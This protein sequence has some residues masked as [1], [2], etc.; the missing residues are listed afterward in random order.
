MARLKPQQEKLLLELIH[1][2]R[3][4]GESNRSPFYATQTFDGADVTHPGF[5]GRNHR[6]Y[7]GD[8]QGL[9]QYGLVM[10]T[11]VDRNLVVFELAP[12]A[13]EYAKNI[14]VSSTEDPAEAMALAYID[15]SQFATRH[16][17]AFDA[18]RKARDA[19][20]VGG[21]HTQLTEVGHWCREAMQAFMS[22]LVR[23]QGVR[24]ADP[25]PAHTVAR[26][27]VV[28]LQRTSEIGETVAGFLNALMAYWGT[29]SDLVQRQEHGAQRDGE[30]L[31][32]HDA[33]RIVFH[34]LAVMHELDASLCH[35]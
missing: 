26:L 24:D 13:Y 3:N 1:A 16:P 32:W 7:W 21:S 20:A 9:L 18:W 25:N 4:A 34:T 11:K 33:R 5:A 10:P 28:V 27:R 15:A 23:S 17:A 22:D 19:V 2:E 12:E 14:G 8:V 6:I 29:L 31:G 35:T 30:V